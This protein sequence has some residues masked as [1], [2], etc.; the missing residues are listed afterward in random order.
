MGNRRYLNKK[1]AD[2]ERPSETQT[3]AS[4]K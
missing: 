4:T 3:M 1:F 2:S